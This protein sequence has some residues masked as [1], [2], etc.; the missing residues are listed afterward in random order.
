MLP[1]SGAHRKPST[2][3][4]LYS[5]YAVCIT[6]LAEIIIALNTGSDDFQKISGSMCCDE[7]NYVIKLCEFICLPICIVSNLLDRSCSF[8]LVSS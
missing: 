3:I 4:F 8:S 2:A 7:N 1:S 5:A 6:T